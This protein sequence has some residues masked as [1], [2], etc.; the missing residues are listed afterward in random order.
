[1]ILKLGNHK[2]YVGRYQD[3][4]TKETLLSSRS[5]WGAFFHKTDE[6]VAAGFLK[7]ARHAVS[8]LAKRAKWSADRSNWAAQ[9]YAYNDFFEYD[10]SL[11]NMGRSTRR[12]V[13]SSRMAG[14]KA[15]S[16]R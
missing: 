16:V 3:L 2:P 8:L 10:W 7:E 14:K 11:E 4:T 13:N 9:K 15:K 5:W 12:I 6:L 1:L